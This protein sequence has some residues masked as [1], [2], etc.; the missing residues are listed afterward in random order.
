MGIIRYDAYARFMELG[1]SEMFRSLG[2]GYHDFGARYGISLPRR[3]QHLEFPSPPR[4]DELLEVVVYI[5]EV[6]TTSL[7]LNFDVYGERGAQ[8]MHGYLVLVCVTD[9]P[10]RGD[11]VVK[12]PWPTAFIETLAPVRMAVAEA[13]ARRPGA[14]P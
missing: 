4:L 14:L 13:R 5:S 9:G 11:A 10:E 1:E 8:R 2:I 3:A 7:V 6:G 12:Q